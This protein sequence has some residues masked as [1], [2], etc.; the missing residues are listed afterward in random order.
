MKSFEDYNDGDWVVLNREDH[1]WHLMSFQAFKSQ[2]THNAFRL[3]YGDRE[4]IADISEIKPL[5]EANGL[6]RPHNGNAPSSIID[7]ECSDGT[8]DDKPN[9]HL[10]QYD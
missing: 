10:Q 9:Y 7:E 2:F 5:N 3:K 1:P 4:Y 8:P 6:I